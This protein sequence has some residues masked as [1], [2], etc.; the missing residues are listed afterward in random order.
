MK[1]LF[2]IILSTITILTL[3]SFHGED[4]YSS[5]TK[6]DFIENSKTLKFT[7]KLNTAHISEAIKSKENSPN[8]ENEVK[9]YINNHFDVTINGG[10]KQLNFT[11]S[12]VNGESVWVY[13]EVNNVS[14]INNLKIKNNIMIA[15]FPKQV[16]MVNISYKG[17]QKNLSFLKGKESGEVS[18]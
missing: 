13:F 3:F 5:I 1:T 11:G 2:K 6:V 9:N 4:F 12:Q 14:E 15:N 10:Q 18:F 16:N 7:T 17:L 8:F